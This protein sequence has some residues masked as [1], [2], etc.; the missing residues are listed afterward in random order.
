MPIPI[1]RETGTMH[2][3]FLPLGQICPNYGTGFGAKPRQP[4]LRTVE[5][6]RR[7]GL[8]DQPI[9]TPLLSKGGVAARSR[10]YRE[11]TLARADGVVG[12]SSNKFVL[13]L[14]PTTLNASRCRAR[15]SRPSAPNKD[16]ARYF[17]EVASTP[18]LLRRGVWL[19]V[20]RSA[21]IGSLNLFWTA[22]PGGRD[23]KK[24]IFPF[25]A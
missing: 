2:F 13:V 6:D 5:H 22:R 16:A 25:S 14:E 9:Q 12:S 24:R 19:A 20:N 3:Y 23:F 21:A 8:R 7:C 10:K 17:I 15:A 1:S 4:W 11:A 18:P